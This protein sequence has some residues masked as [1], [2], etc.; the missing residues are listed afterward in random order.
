MTLTVY[1]AVVVGVESE[2]CHAAHAERVAELLRQVPVYQAGGVTVLTSNTAT[3]SNIHQSVRPQNTDCDV[4]FFYFAGHGGPTGTLAAF[5]QRQLAFTDLLNWLE[6]SVAKHIILYF[7]GCY[8]G[9]MI[10][11]LSPDA[12]SRFTLLLGSRGASSCYGM[13]GGVSSAHFFELGLEGFLWG[14]LTKLTCTQ[15]VMFINN[16]VEAW[17]QIRPE[18]NIHPLTIWGRGD[19]PLAIKAF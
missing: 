10:D 16:L 2:Q 8:S 11:H 15:I 7:D 3:S 4:L 12:H 17:H 1:R 6:E 5:D 13:H 19:V 14:S 18:L 9:K